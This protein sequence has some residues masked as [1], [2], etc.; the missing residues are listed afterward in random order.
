MDKR[1]MY[2]EAFR[3]PLIVHWPKGVQPETVNVCLINNTDF[4]PTM[5]ELAGVAT[6]IGAISSA[7]CQWQTA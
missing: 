6:P 1:W 5:L 4:A 7:G 2:E 3:M